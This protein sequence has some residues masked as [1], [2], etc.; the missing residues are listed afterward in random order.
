VSWRAN[1]ETIDTL[2]EERHDHA[3][4]MTAI[5]DLRSLVFPIDIR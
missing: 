1:D 2:S 5:E 3:G 4:T